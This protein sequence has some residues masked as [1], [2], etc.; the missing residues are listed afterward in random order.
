MKVRNNTYDSWFVLEVVRPAD[1]LLIN[2]YYLCIFRWLFDQLGLFC[3]NL[4]EKKVN[5]IISVMKNIKCFELF[6][7]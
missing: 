5:T 2:C 1:E 6:K 3:A 4:L 7:Y